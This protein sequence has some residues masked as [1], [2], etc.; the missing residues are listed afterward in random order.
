MTSIADGAVCIQT[1]SESIPATPSWFGEVVQLTAHLRKHG[2]F[3]RINEQV[4]FARRRFGHYD[5]IDFLAVL[6]GCAIGGERTLDLCSVW[7]KSRT[8]LRPYCMVN[9]RQERRGLGRPMRQILVRQCT[10]LAG[11]SLVGSAGSSTVRLSLTVLTS[12]SYLSKTCYMRQLLHRSS[13]L[14]YLR[15]APDSFSLP[16]INDD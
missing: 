12:L 6:F 14:C 13:G 5:V 4:R 15:N 11:A 16:K 7:S 8:R 2:I 10:P 9:E 1:A 3:N